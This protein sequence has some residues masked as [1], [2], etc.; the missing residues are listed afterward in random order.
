[1]LSSLACLGFSW[2]ETIAGETLSDARMAS[3]GLRATVTETIAG[4]RPPR[5]GD[6]DEHRAPRSR[7]LLKKEMRRGWVSATAAAVKGE[8]PF[9]CCIGFDFIPNGE[10]LSALGANL[11]ELLAFN[12]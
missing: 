10:C 11:F 4:D 3:E 7:L 12:C 5:Y 2:T 6:G 1:M 8:S 9:V